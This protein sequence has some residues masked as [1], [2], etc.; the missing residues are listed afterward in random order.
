MCG[1]VGFARRPHVINEPVVLRK[2]SG[3][4]HHR[5]PDSDGYWLD[6]EIALSHT[7]LSILDLSEF[8]EQP[9]QSQNGRYVIVFNGEIYNHR[10]IRRSLGAH[11]WRGTSDTETLIIAIEK[12]GIVP[13]L[14]R[15][16]G[17]FA[18]AVWDRSERTLTIARDRLGEKPLYYGWLRGKFVFASE[19]KA[20]R[21]HPD[22]V[23]DISRSALQSFVRL[24]YVPTPHGIYEGIYKLP[25]GNTLTVKLGSYVESGGRHDPMPYWKASQFLPRVNETIS[26]P[27][28]RLEELLTQSIRRQMIADVPVGAFLSGGIDSSLVVAIMQRE[29]P[30]PVE[31]FSIGF[32]EKAYDEAVYA[33]R[34]AAHLGT[35]HTE[36]YVSAADA[37]S[38]IPDLPVI[39]DEP[40][41]DVSGLPTTLVSRLARQRVTVSLSGDGGDELFGGYNRYTWARK[42]LRITNIMP[43]RAREL[44][45][46]CI[47]SVSPRRWDIAAKAISAAFL[48]QEQFKNFGDR[49]HK[50]AGV[51]D[52]SSVSELYS[53]LTSQ[54]VESSDLVID[55]ESIETWS[56]RECAVYLSRDPVEIMMLRDLTG[57]LADDILAKV[58]RA[59]MSTSLESRMPLLDHEIVEFALSLRLTQKIRSGRGKMPMRNLLSRYLPQGLIDRPKQGFGVPI[60]DWLRG[61]LRDW[62]ESLLREYRLKEE[63]YFH[64]APIRK[65]WIEHIG[66]SRN[67]QYLL[68]N[69]LMFQAWLDYE[70]STT[71][72]QVKW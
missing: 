21:E 31:T 41:A 4:L 51:I 20:L 38:L 22:W 9:M 34:V 50:F 40:F 3:T 42:I 66:G 47:L 68:W 28:G 33:K 1:I 11:A 63:G 57:Y 65:K 69:I 8:G 29:S 67:W 55:G 25:P 72:V 27:V 32:S 54:W 71:R 37:M 61:P 6:N 46:R 5:G 2:M 49:L 15:V 35:S 10:E 17:M 59:S 44:I 14:S 36:L 24:G 16:T 48:R 70:R 60:D 13:A 18:F 52:V 64:P 12:W 43:L 53:R 26:D 23:G 7:R 62:A 56:E 19:L 45:R 58:D 30:Y 39:Y